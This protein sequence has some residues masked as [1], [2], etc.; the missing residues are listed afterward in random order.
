VS[1]RILDVPALIDI[2]AGRTQFMRARWHVAHQTLSTLIVPWCAAAVAAREL[3]EDG[4][5]ALLEALSAPMVVIGPRD[6]AS[7]VACGSLTDAL[8]GRPGWDAAQVVY[9]AT[10]RTWPV[11][12]SEA[13]L[14][15]LLAINPLITFERLP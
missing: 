10:R 4:R 3:G 1:N 11:V 13:N 2:A 9:E 8:G 14:D 15:R 12:T 7:A 6:A 5:Q